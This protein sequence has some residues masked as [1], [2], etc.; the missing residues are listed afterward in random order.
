M[1]E[2]KKERILFWDILKGIGI[3]SIVFGHSQNS[4]IA[5][6]TVYYYHLAVFFFISGYLYNEERY[7]DR[8]FEF[9][10]RRLQNMWLP[11]VC[12]GGSFVL[13]HNFLVRHHFFPGQLYGGRDMLSAMMNTLLLNCAE[14]PSGAL[15]FV[16]V[17]LG[18]GAGFSAV[19][20]ICRS[21]V[22]VKIR[23]A[24]LGVICLL[25]GL[26][27]VFL[28]RRGIGLAYH[29]QTAVLVLPVY[30]G[31]YLFRRG[32]IAP[33][34][35]AAWYGAL[36]CIALFWYFLAV[37]GETI[38]LSANV[39]PGGILFYIITGAG[40]YLCCFAAKC[41]E[42]IP[43]L[44]RA[45]ALAGRHSF[46]I[47]ALHFLVF[48][49]IDGI[50]GRLLCAPVETYGIFPHSY[51]ELHWVY[52]AGGVLLPLGAAIVFKR[53]IHAA[54]RSLRAFAVSI[55]APHGTML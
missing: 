5:I 8:P 43:Y 10:G 41:L 18:T 2:E 12:Y 44:G 20:W 42:R 35:S 48:K 11:Y 15:G 29:L 47:M 19:V 45:A 51:P 39:V 13:L 49:G 54:G 23:S 31:G 34:K 46:D 7:G 25:I 16:P 1:A 22:P 40:I 32:R 26:F 38:E 28:N 17:M 36:V 53:V 27:G 55:A 24:V 4:G 37:S 9:F 30:C 50:Y 14:G 52:L 21:F 3:I 6:R 33:E